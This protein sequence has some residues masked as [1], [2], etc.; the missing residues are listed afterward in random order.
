MIDL[1]FA[2]TPNG[3]KVSIMLEECGLGYEPK[4][5]RL[6]EGEQFLDNFLKISPNAKIPAF[7]DYSPAPEWGKS[8][9][10][11]FESAAILLY[12]ADKT[13]LFVP[14]ASDLRARIF[15]R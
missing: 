9:V 6:S 5:V 3:W 4:L 10:S 11:V 7:I 14:S 13:K 1:Y 15:L 8:Q 12:L 2:P